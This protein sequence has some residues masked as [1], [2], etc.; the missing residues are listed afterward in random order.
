MRAYAVF[1][2][3]LLISGCTKKSDVYMFDC[4]IYD[5]KVDAAVEGASIVMKVQ[6][7]S[8]GGFNPTYET[9]GSATTDASGRFYLEVPK[10]VYYSF[11][12]VVTHPNHFSQNFDINPNNVPFST[13]YSATFDVEPKAWVSTHL[14]NQNLSQTATFAVD[15]N[16]DECT[17]C[18]PSS[19]TILQGASVDTTFICEVYGEQQISV[20]GTYVDENGGVHQIA[21]TAFVQ[22]FDTTTVT[23]TY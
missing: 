20:N 16:T 23:I 7:V 18:C 22:A 12:V 4:T 17:E 2:F 11:R 6:K 8:G 19:N 14:L 13:A 1:L 21:E 15:A 10:D 9:V 3:V 5:Q